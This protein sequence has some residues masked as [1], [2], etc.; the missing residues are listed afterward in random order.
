M[1]FIVVIVNV[2]G[3]KLRAIPHI[4]RLLN[5][6]ILNPKH[7][8][9]ACGTATGPIIVFLEV[10]A[11]LILAAPGV[12]T[13]RPVSHTRQDCA[14]PGRIFLLLTFIV[15]PQGVRSARGIAAGPMLVLLV[16][17]TVVVLAGLGLHAI[18]TICCGG[19]YVAVPMLLFLLVPL[20]V[21]PE[22]VAPAS[23]VAAGPMFIL[24]VAMAAGML[25]VP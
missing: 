14:I 4:V 24:P 6:F 1:P 19:E 21:F 22:I 11:P 12:H 16:A 13:I 15:N 7:F 20:A 8:R 17:T 18:L 5:P 3:E 2:I 9:R 10:G 23:L 25:A